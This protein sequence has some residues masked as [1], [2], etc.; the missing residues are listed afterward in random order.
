MEIQRELCDP[1]W[2]WKVS[3]LLRNRRL[4]SGFLSQSRWRQRQTSKS[5]LPSS[6]FTSLWRFFRP[7]GFVSYMQGVLNLDRYEWIWGVNDKEWAP[8]C[9]TP[10]VTTVYLFNY[11]RAIVL[12]KVATEM[13]TNASYECCTCRNFPLLTNRKL[14]QPRR[15]RHL[16]K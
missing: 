3:G 12:C 11:V 4:A 13:Y 8:L 2:A 15:P 7:I 1:K 10:R 6:K 9:C 14:K 16:K 5:L